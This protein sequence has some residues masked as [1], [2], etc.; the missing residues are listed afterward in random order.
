MKKRDLIIII[1]FLAF[2]FTFGL[3]YFFIPDVEFS[4]NENKYLDQLPKVSLKNIMNGK[5]ESDFEAYMSDQI[6]GR[7][8]WMSC[9]TA[10]LLA[11]G[12]NDV[13]GVY[14]GKDG[15]LL[16]IFD[17]L[18]FDR[19]EKQIDALNKFNSYVD[20]PVYFVIAPNSVSV[21]EDKLPDYAVNYSQD[22][23]IGD[24]YDGLD[25]DIVSIDVSSVLK[26]HSEEYIYY[27]TD[28]HWT[29]YG[30]FIAFN[31][32]ARV[33]GIR[34]LSLDEVA[35]TDVSADF[36]GTFFSKG[37]FIIDPDVIQRFD[38]KNGASYKVILDGGVES[39]TLYDDS[40]LLKKDKYAYFTHGNPAH[41]SVETESDSDKTLVIVKDSY[42]HCMLQFFVPSYKK[43]HMV[44]PRYI[45]TNLTEYITDL[46]PD[47]ILILY[48]AKTLSDEVNFTRL[49][50]APKN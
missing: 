44:D 31:E 36:L 33:M 16:E 45:K 49:G 9:N 42:M 12:K 13:N 24:F 34:T 3:L 46:E 7:D 30:S 2:I 19:Y 15:Y 22:K 40:Y 41:L 14:V 17:G 11:S 47:E 5:F 1:P 25:S 8:F 35:V 4:E 43:I 28:H 48:N 6:A 23:Y 20:V 38:V 27:R 21:H 18:D 37:N 29:T 39:D 50:T 10:L 32:I 26:D